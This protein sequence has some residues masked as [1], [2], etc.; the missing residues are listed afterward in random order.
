MHT[1]KDILKGSGITVRKF[2]SYNFGDKDKMKAVF[3]ESFKLVDKTFPQYQHLPEY[4]QIIEWLNNTE[5]KGLFMTGSFGRGKS[6]ILYGVIPLI[7]RACYDKVLKPIAARDLHKADLG[8]AIS[9]DDIGQEE[10]VNDFG[11]KID[12]VEYAISHCEDNMKL[13]VMSANL[14]SQQLEERYGGRIL[15]R[16]NRLCKVVEFKGKSLRQ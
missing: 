8:W 13:L 6:T 11:T 10:I 7:F 16:I 1:L 14:N 2:D 3:I 4:T 12:A 5:G 9:I 15:D